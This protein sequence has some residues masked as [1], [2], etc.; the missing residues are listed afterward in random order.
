MNMYMKTSQP[1]LEN[2][3]RSGSKSKLEKIWWISLVIVFAIG[4]Y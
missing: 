4:I 2:Q 3:L 1:P